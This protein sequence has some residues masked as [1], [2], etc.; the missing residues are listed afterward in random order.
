MGWFVNLTEMS[1]G[2][3]RSIDESFELELPMG[4]QGTHFSFESRQNPFSDFGRDQVSPHAHHERT[5]LN[6]DKKPDRH[7]Q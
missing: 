7:T 2:F 3:A 6:G 1:M 5:H 4:E